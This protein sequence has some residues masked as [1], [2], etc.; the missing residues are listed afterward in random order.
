MQ[1]K[2]CPMCDHLQYCPEILKE[3]LIIPELFQEFYSKAINNAGDMVSLLSRVIIEVLLPKLSAAN[4]RVDEAEAACAAM[5]EFIDV[6]RVCCIIQRVPSSSCSYCDK[7]KICK[8]TPKEILQSNVGAT[9]LA[10]LREAEY[11]RELAECQRDL[12][13]K[14]LTARDAE[15]QQAHKRIGELES[16]LDI[17]PRNCFLCGNLATE[18][19]SD[20][21]PED[22]CESCLEELE[23]G[24]E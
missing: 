3:E 19:T 24:G 9:F 7:Q 18:L 23:K 10:R 11:M 2:R 14:N 13:I 16:K 8:T 21:D 6:I 1:G 22:I 4:K 15:L 20:E 17:S 5:R 12:Q